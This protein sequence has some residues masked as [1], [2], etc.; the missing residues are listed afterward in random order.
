MRRRR[1]WWWRRRWLQQQ[2]ADDGFGLPIHLVAGREPDPD[3]LGPRLEAFAGPLQRTCSPVPEPYVRAPDR[4]ALGAEPDAGAVAADVVAVVAQ[5]WRRRDVDV[6]VVVQVVCCC[7]C[8]WGGEQFAERI[9]G[10][11]VEDAGVPT[12][13]AS[14]ASSTTTSTATAAPLPSKVVAVIGLR[15]VVAVGVAEGVLVRLMLRTL[16][17]PRLIMGWVRPILASPPIGTA[18][19][20]RRRRARTVHRMIIVDAYDSRSPSIIR[21]GS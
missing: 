2:D 11:V 6:V 18:A 19:V 20:S 7:S 1:L 21:V 9:V 5:G 13:A 3:L 4:G 12:S 16:L 10:R 8:C 17:I 14:P 15:V